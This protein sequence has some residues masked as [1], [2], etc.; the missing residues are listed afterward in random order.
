MN[1]KKQKVQTIQYLLLHLFQDPRS[2]GPRNEA[3]LIYGFSNK[4][5]CTHQISLHLVPCEDYIGLYALQKHDVIGEEPVRYIVC[6]LY[7]H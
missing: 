6:I 5:K 7:V 1:L 4:Y 2:A 3:N